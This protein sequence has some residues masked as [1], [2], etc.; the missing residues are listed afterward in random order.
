MR[1]GEGTRTPN[2]QLGKLA[3]EAPRPLENQGNPHADSARCTTGCTGE[4]S[5][6]NEDPLAAFVASL[7]LEQR[8]RLAVLL[9]A[10]RDMDR[11]LPP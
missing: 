9:L 11:E 6:P 3:V 10:E 4:G 7:A 1:S 2:V 8:R 5:E